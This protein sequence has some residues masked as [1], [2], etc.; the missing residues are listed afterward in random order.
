MIEEIPTTPSV[1]MVE[2]EDPDLV[3]PFFGE[4]VVEPLRR[5]Y[6]H[7]LGNSMRR[8]LLS[9]LPGAAVSSIRVDGV[10]HEFSSIPDVKEDVTQIVLNI[11]KLRMRSYSDEPVKAQLD[12][13]G[14]G[15][16]RASDVKWPDQVE[17]VNPEQIIATLDNENARLSMELTVTRGEGYVAAESVEGQPI[18]E[19]PV[20]AIY[21]PTRRVEYHIGAARVGQSVNL[22]R[23]ELRVWTDGTTTPEEAVSRAAQMLVEQFRVFTQLVPG[24]EI[25]S[26]TAVARPA[27]PSNTLQVPQELIDVSVDDLELSNRTLNCLKRNSITRV[28]QLASMTEDD[29][30]HLRNFGDK[31]LNELRDKLAERGVRIGPSAEPAAV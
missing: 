14:P 15:I 26:E 23:L 3:D 24:M 6:G 21:S 12:V 11:K 16:V 20:D 9:S 4:F 8:V 10:Q 17:I 31:S 18:G 29:L 13:P 7:T 22:D 30:L 19:I 2:P 27:L 5:G 25:P 28:G 1:R